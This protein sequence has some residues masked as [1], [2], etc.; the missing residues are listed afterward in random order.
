MT[1][2]TLQKISKSPQN[3]LNETN[4]TKFEKNSEFGA[5]RKCEDSVEYVKS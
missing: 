1:I 4:G 3:I 5:V 2:E